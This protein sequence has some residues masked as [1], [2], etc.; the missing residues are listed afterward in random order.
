M[1]T[2]GLRCQ[3][4]YR[5]QDSKSILLATKSRTPTKRDPVDQNSTKSPKKIFFKKVVRQALANGER[6]YQQNHNKKHQSLATQ[7]GNFSTRP[8]A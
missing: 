3:L 4:E 7:K 5:V 6:D 8:N 2:V 1:S